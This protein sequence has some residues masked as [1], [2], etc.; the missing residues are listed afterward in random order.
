MSCWD[1]VLLC[2]AQL[3]SKSPVKAEKSSGGVLSSKEKDL[4]VR[5]RLKIQ[6]TGKK[7]HSVPPASC[8]EI[9]ATRGGRLALV[10]K[11]KAQRGQVPRQK[12]HSDQSCRGTGATQNF[13]P[14]IINRV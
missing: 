4:E 11:E 3:T 1:L 7:E 2:Q 12:P 9:P 13:L 14:L 8:S 10:K 6:G 5:K